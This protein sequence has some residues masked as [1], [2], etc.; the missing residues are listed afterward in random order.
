MQYGTNMKDVLI[1]SLVRACSFLHC[2]FIKLVIQCQLFFRDDEKISTKAKV[3]YFYFFYLYPANGSCGIAMSLSEVP[4]MDYRLLFVN[5]ITQSGFNICHPPAPVI[6]C[7]IVKCYIG[8]VK[9]YFE[10]AATP[11]Q[12]HFCC[13][14]TLAT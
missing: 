11:K 9:P 2:Y 13:S 5:Q 7:A 10:Y 1:F 4:A 12:N 8:F 14:L 6:Q 3:F